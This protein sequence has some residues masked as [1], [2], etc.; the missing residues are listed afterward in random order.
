MLYNKDTKQVKKTIGNAQCLECKC[1]DKEKKVC[2]GL[3]KICYEYDEKTKT[4][5]D[6][7]TK[8]PIKFND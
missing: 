8:L 3:G 6:S 5:I 2:N 4:V 1:F 7:I